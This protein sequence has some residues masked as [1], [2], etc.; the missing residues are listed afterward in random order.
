[1][2]RVL[3][4]LGGIAAAFVAWW[5][6]A[7][8]LGIAM[9]ALWPPT[10][11]HTAGLSLEPQNV[12]GNALGFVLALYAFRAITRPRKEPSGVQPAQT[13]PVA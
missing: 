12:P 7:V 3:H 4:E 11:S 5:A 2:Q 8:V 6:V 9:F 1:M 10:G 13:R